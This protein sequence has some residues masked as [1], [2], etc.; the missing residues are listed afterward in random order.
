MLIKRMFSDNFMLKVIALGLAVI[1][2]FVINQITSY[3]KTFENIPI[4]VLVGDGW[5][6]QDLSHDSFK[7]SFRG[8]REDIAELDPATVKLRVDL[9]A[10]PERDVHA[11]GLKP[12][13][14]LFPGAGHPYEITPSTVYIQI[15]QIDQKVVS[16]KPN[17]I[18]ELAYGYRSESATSAPRSVTLTGSRRRLEEIV[19]VQTAPIDL[20]GRIKSFSHKVDILLP[21]D[22]WG[23][24]AEPGRVDVSVVLVG[25]EAERTLTNVAVQVMSAP[26]I[27][28]LAPKLTPPFVSVK[29]EGRSSLIESLT[30]EQILA[31]VRVQDSGRSDAAEMA[32]QV[33]VPAG[34]SVIEVMPADVQVL[35]SASG[36][37]AEPKE[38]V[39]VPAAPLIEEASDGNEN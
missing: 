15:D 14:V 30:A 36:S 3:E 18:G 27:D 1:S 12:K 37:E 13:N 19:S 32:V 22:D 23:V 2:W 9:R 20:T 35:V 5:S 28:L 25:Q 4:E 38:A 24:E 26:G 11:F 6:I 29:V 39:P 21:S 34:V 16:V 10:E 31:F 17:V 33:N 8:S 7:V